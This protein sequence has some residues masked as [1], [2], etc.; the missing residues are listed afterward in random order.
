MRAEE[1][2]S[3][4]AGPRPLLLQEHGAGEGSAW[5]PEWGLFASDAGHIMRRARDGQI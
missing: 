1:V 3:V 2:P 5:H 4:F